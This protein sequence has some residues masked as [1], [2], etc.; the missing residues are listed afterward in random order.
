[1]K[2]KVDITEFNRALKDYVLESKMDIGDAVNKQ[3]IKV[4]FYANKKS[5]KANDGTIPPKGS[6]L[7]YALAASG[8]NKYGKA[9]KGKGIG[10]IA[11]KIASRRFSAVSYNK[12][13]WLKLAIDLGAQVGKASKRMM[14]MEHVQGAKAQ[15]N[16]RT[17]KPFATLIIGGLKGIEADNMREHIAPALQSA[18]ILAAKD[19]QVYINRKLRE[20]GARYSGRGRSKK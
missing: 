3:A 4:A 19:M 1:M 13:M 18:V 2:I 10:K 11:R 5:S 17:D 15:T 20:R 12:A 7:Y 6:R 16:G 14:K 8:E 9:V